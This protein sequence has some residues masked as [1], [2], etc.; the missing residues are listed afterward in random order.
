MVA[1]VQIRQVGNKLT[2]QRLL[3]PVAA[4]EAT[5][6]A[7]AKPVRILIDVYVIFMYMDGG[8]SQVDTFDYKPLLEK[9]NGQDPR[10]AIGKLEPTQFNSM[11]AFMKDFGDMQN[12][13]QVT[14]LQALLKP[15]MLRRMKEDVEKSLKPK[16]ETIVEV[17]LTNIQKKYYRGILEK[18]EV[19]NPFISLLFRIR[20]RTEFQVPGVEVESPPDTFSGS[21]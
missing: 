13:E 11:D 4:L 9:F 15:L 8:P 17:E 16:E 3:V 6:T 14:K 20:T 7:F 5:Y 10:K 1:V 12:E 19:A 18:N 21:V 2:G